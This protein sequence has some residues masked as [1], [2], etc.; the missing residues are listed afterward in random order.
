MWIYSEKTMHKLRN[1]TGKIPAS[2]DS[3]WVKDQNDE[4]RLNQVL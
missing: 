1:K 4:K 2:K 3:E